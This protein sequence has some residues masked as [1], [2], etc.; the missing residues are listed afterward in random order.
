[1]Q[2]LQLV[3]AAPVFYADKI[4]Q[5]FYKNSSQYVNIPQRLKQT[6]GNSS[7]YQSIVTE[8]VEEFKRRNPTITAWSDLSLCN[9]VK[10]TLD[11]N[12]RLT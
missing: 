10:T 4:N 8:S 7:F 6:I 2:P 9:S 11:K 3:T 5:Q 1:M 12:S